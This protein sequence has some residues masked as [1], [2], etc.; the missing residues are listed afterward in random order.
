MCFD[1]FLTSEK[2][3][4]KKMPILF[5]NDASAVRVGRHLW[6]IGGNAICGDIKEKFDFEMHSTM[7][8]EFQAFGT[9]T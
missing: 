4:K 3:K 6:I 8:F 7:K 1:T 9:P 2:K 5:E